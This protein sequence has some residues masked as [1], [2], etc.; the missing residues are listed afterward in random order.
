MNLD[1]VPTVVFVVDPRLMTRRIRP[2]L[3]T[4]AV[5]VIDARGGKHA[6]DRKEPFLGILEFGWH[7]DAIVHQGLELYGR[8]LGPWNMN[9]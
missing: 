9:S 5:G 4:L 1:N 7:I 8:D 6:L 2:P 3:E